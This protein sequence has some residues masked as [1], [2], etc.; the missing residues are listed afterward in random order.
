[1]YFQGDANGFMA[2]DTMVPIQIRA[3]RSFGIGSGKVID[4]RNIKYD[5]KNLESVTID[6]LASHENIEWK[7]DSSLEG[8]SSGGCKSHFTQKKN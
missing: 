4:V 6:V 5:S 2:S 7:Q 8:T 1:M 3:R